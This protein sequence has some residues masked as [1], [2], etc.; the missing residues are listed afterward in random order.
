MSAMTETEREELYEKAE[1]L[2]GR[3]AQLAKAAEEFAELSAAVNRLQNDQATIEEVISEIADGKIMLEQLERD[4]SDEAID[5]AFQR[6][7]NALK[8]RQRDTGN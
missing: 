7:L 4:F 1:L 6:K 5:E 3:D 2:W 8:S